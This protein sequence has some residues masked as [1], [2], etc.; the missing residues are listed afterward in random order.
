ME[1]RGVRDRVIVAT[2]FTTNYKTHVDGL[3]RNDVI[4]YGGNHK[5]SLHMSV[6]DSLK[7][8]K[9]EWIDVLYLHW[10][11]FSTSIKEVMDSLHVLVEQGKVL[12]LGISGAP[13]AT[14]TAPRVSH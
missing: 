4:L 14:C 1:S 11:D 10:W 8:L 7:K 13:S 2:K 5:R 12:Y 9:T 3:D 6:R